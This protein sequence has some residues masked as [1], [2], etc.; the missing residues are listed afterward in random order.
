MLSS[1]PPQ[2][3][4]GQVIW[5]R[6]RRLPSLFRSILQALWAPRTIQP[7]SAATRAALPENFSLFASL[8][9]ERPCGCT[10]ALRTRWQHLA[11]FLSVGK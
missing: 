4:P 11:T 2:I 1:P 10:R 3:Q 9:F 5:R 8:G 6:L 7:S